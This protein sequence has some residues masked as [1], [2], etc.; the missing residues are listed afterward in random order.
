MFTKLY[1]DSTIAK[2]KKIPQL[3][4][5][6]FYGISTMFAELFMLKAMGEDSIAIVNEL[7]TGVKASSFLILYY[8]TLLVVQVVVFEI[9]A[10]FANTL[11]IRRFPEIANSDFVFKLRLTLIIALLAIGLLSLPFFAYPPMADIGS[12]VITVAIK[13]FMLG[14][15]L[16]ELSKMFAR[17]P[18]LA[19]KYLATLYIGINL[20][21]S[22]LPLVMLFTY[23]NTAPME[24]VYFA[25]KVGLYLLATVFAY[26]QYNKLKSLPPKDDDITIIRDDKVFKDF[27][28]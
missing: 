22:I 17:K 19:Y 8:P 1:S 5:Y 27:G 6:L 28:F 2:L 3:V 15:F 18:H 25:I 11:M 12:A 21:L 23:E 13:V 9:I 20:A 14:M 26:F 7:V 4:W 24:Y 16:F 10:Y